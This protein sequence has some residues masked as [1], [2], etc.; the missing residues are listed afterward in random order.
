MK[1]KKN[2]LVAKVLM[3]LF[4]DNSFCDEV[5]LNY[6]PSPQDFRRNNTSTNSSFTN[7]SL[8]NP[9]D[10]NPSDTNP[11]YPSYP[12]YTNPSYSPSLTN[13]P[14][15]DPSDTNPSY[16]GSLCYSEKPPKWCRP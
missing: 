6:Y 12:S 3:I 1:N 9:P 11:S 16:L 14:D 5:Q 8:T 13:P 7:P 2:M 10:P 4:S 15:P